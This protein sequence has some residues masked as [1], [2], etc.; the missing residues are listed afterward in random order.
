MQYSQAEKP[1]KPLA[2]SYNNPK[3]SK[4]MQY[5]VYI[6]NHRVSSKMTM[7]MITS[8]LAGMELLMAQNP[9]FDEPEPSLWTNEGD[10]SGIMTESPEFVPPES[11]VIPTY[12]YSTLHPNTYYH[13][14]K[15]MERQYR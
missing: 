12:Y 1:N 15:S 6:Q 5:S 11:T 2:S 9:F 4:K 10:L 8:R 13:L 14:Q 3:L 7:Q